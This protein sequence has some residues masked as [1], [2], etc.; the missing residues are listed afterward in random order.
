RLGSEFVG[1]L[2]DRMIRRPGPLEEAHRTLIA[3]NPPHFFT[4]DFLKGVPSSI[5]GLTFENPYLLTIDRLPRA[6]W[7]TAHSIIGKVGNGP[8][9][10]CS[11][12]V[13]PYSSSHLEW[14]ASE[15]IIN[16]SHFLQDDPQTIVELRRILFLHLAE[17]G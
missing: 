2:G 17:S 8:L 9:E 7:V 3:E 4:A 15:K 10:T 5:D 11:D 12:G 13:V 14:V 1:R 6:P 16:R